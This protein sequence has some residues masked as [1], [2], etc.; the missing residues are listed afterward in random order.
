MKSDS[1]NKPKN[2]QHDQNGP[3]GSMETKADTAE[4]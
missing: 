3:V 4:K 2:G 1:A